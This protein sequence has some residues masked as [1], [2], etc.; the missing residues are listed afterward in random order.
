L[1]HVVYHRPR[2]WD[3]VPKGKHV[4]QG[5]SALWGD[6]H[7]LELAVYLKRALG[8]GPCHTFHGPG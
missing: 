4:P 8:G 2:G 6:Y 5:E 1:L 7:L 3:Y